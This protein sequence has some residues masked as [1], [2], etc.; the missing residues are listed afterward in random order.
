MFLGEGIYLDPCLTWHPSYYKA[1]ALCQWHF[2][3][4][5][6]FILSVSCPLADVLMSAYVDLYVGAWVLCVG[7]SVPVC[8]CMKYLEVFFGGGGPGACRVG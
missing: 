1:S 6:P 7:V 3:C 8:V 2:I 5:D 4:V